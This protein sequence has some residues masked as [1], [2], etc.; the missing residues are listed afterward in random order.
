MI[1]IWTHPLHRIPQFVAF[2]GIFAGLSSPAWADGDLSL[3]VAVPGLSV[4]LGNNPGYYAHL[5]MRLRQCITRRHRAAYIM[6]LRRHLRRLCAINCP[7]IM[8][9]RRPFAI[10]GPVLGSITVHR[11]G[12]GVGGMMMVMMAGGVSFIGSVV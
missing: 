9:S 6:F 10:T 1:K 7:G 12:R 4:F 8:C 2:V 5:F 11:H 3:G